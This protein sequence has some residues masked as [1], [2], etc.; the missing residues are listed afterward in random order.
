MA[1]GGGTHSDNGRRSGAHR[2]L[3]RSGDSFLFSA[4]GELAFGHDLGGAAH[5]LFYGDG[6]VAFAVANELAAAA[7]ELELLV[8]GGTGI[9][10]EFSTGLI[11]F[12]G[13]GRDGVVRANAV[14]FTFATGVVAAIVAGEGQL[15]K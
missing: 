7:V 13:L 11:H 14:T 9:G 3:F 6:F 1:V 2:F 15:G 5:V 8:A 4:F 12:D 10:P